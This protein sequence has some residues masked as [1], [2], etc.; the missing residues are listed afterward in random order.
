[1]YNSSN[2]LI[3]KINNWLTLGILLIVFLK[4]FICFVWS[5]RLL[6]VSATL[7]FCI[8]SDLWPPA[9]RITFVLALFIPRLPSSSLLFSLSFT[10]IPFFPLRRLDLRLFPPPLLSCSSLKC[11]LCTLI[12]FNL[13]YLLSLIFS[14]HFFL[15]AF[16]FQVKF[17]SSFFL[18]CRANL[19]LVFYH[20]LF[21][22]TSLMFILAFYLPTCFYSFYIRSFFLN[23]S[24]VPDPC[25]LP[26]LT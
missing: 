8:K 7:L 10:S 12:P 11:A 14:D 4:W 20:L 26:L 17:F 19:H 9:S 1:M 16:I 21:L 24:S 18:F 2:N 25:P 6:S 23:L 3:Y 22:C 13:I 15:S 5:C